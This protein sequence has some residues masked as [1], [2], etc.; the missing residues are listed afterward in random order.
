MSPATYRLLDFVADSFDPVL[1][2]LAALCP[3]RAGVR[4]P[5]S[6]VAYYAAAA[7]GV[8]VVYLIRAIDNHLQIWA[9]AGLDYS[10][11]SAL[12]AS[13]VAS[14]LAFR[15]R[16]L[17]PLT[18]ALLLY[19]CLELLM[20]YHGVLDI[21]TSVLPTASAAAIAHLGARKLA[22]DA[23]SPPETSSPRSPGE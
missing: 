2:L 5:R 4:S 8:A 17:L 14:I 16:W 23:A 18:S 3:W 13:L 11:H 19:F 7:L 21:L 12:A 20:K 15:R 6:R 1:I 10:T 9:S 22:R